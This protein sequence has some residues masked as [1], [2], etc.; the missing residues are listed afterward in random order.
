MDVRRE[1]P[2][3]DGNPIVHLTDANFDSEILSSQEPAMVDFTATWCSPCRQLAPIVEQLAVAYT[4]KLKVGK[5]D[6]DESQATAQR[7]RIR[8]VPTLLFFRGGQI[9]DTVVGFT[10]KAKLEDRIQKLL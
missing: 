4:G 10:P 7:Y 2:M 1:T 8:G 5:L 9:V 6:I 3:A